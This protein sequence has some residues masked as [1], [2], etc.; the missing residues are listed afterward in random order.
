MK[1]GLHSFCAEF[2]QRI[3]K[4]GDSTALVSITQLEPKL[5]SYHELGSLVQ[6][7]AA[8]FT[9][10]G[11]KQNDVVC[12]F[13]QNSVENAV[14]FLTAL[15]L[16]LG[17]A[18]FPC[19]AS[20]REVQGWVELVKP[21]LCLTSELINQDI[22][23]LIEEKKIPSIHIPTDSTF[24]WLP[25]SKGTLPDLTEAKLFLSTSGTT[26]E[27]KAIVLDANTLWSS[28]VA[29]AEFHGITKAG[30]RFWNFLPMSYLGGLFNLC[31]IPLATGGSAIIDETFSGKTI[32]SFWQTIDRY[33]INALWM[34]PSIANGLIAMAER[35]K[36]NFNNK[37]SDLIKVAFVG[38]S[39][40]RLSIK[41][42]WKELF[43][44]ELLENF[45]LSETTFFTS[46]TKNNIQNRT[47]ASVGEILPYAQVAFVD[48]KLDE[49][50]PGGTTP[51]E[52]RVKSPYLFDGYLQ[53]DGTI[54]RALDENGFFP[55]KDLGLLEK[56]RNVT[57]TGRLRDVIKKGG[58]FV[59]L[60]EI[61]VLVE[62]HPL[63]KEAAAVRISHDFYGESF[64]LYVILKDA[65]AMGADD[66][67]NRY[68]HEN[69][70]K[71]KWPDR[72]YL[73]ED[74]PRTASGKVRK[75]LLEGGK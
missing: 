13:V 40:I 7:C 4:G 49:A 67:L 39:P 61:E 16:G 43:G 41:E 55:T 18:P 28:G 35:T 21:T 33:E 9:S 10:K 65:S 75:H 22:H 5:I 57:I 42:R 64:N 54:D 24:S 72:L 44:F 3:A 29:F 48:V 19:S 20:K 45:A 30:L 60:R 15:R 62:K 68:I 73:R 53:P 47:E 23:V 26:G 25:T 38:M 11:L 1:N 74:F 17:Y 52:I 63:V 56:N 50:A 14:C 66:E 27:P 36:Y 34:S 12:A 46:E 69:L 59:S 58:F 70:I 51:K 8:L 31:L 37:Y 2:D 32:L 71:Y 6:R